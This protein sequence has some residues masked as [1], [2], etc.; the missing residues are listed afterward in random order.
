VV[1]VATGHGIT[2][3]Q[4]LS[5][6]VHEVPDTYQLTVRSTKWGAWAVGS[7]PGSQLWQVRGRWL[8]A[9]WP[10]RHPWGHGEPIGFDKVI[11]DLDRYGPIAATMIAGPSVALDTSVGL[12]AAPLNGLMAPGPIPDDH[13]ILTTAAPYRNPNTTSQPIP[14]SS[15]AFT[16]AGLAREVEKRRQTLGPRFPLLD[17][18]APARATVDGGDWSQDVFE[19]T[20]GPS[21]LISA[22]QNLASMYASAERFE[23]CVR[24]VGP[25]LT[26]R[27]ARMGRALASPHFERPAIDQVGF[28]LRGA[29]R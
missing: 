7:P 28:G 16:S 12:W 5:R 26:W 9:G 3:T 8:V 15:P 6:V 1:W 19:S 22:P 14:D 2:P 23:H 25:D 13:R 4:L 10:D 24:V 20:D 29:L 17:P 18:T 21:K 11:D 27:A